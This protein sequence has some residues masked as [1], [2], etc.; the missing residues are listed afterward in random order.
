MTEEE[1]LDDN[2]QEEE[3]GTPQWFWLTVLAGIALG[4]LVG[5]SYQSKTPPRYSA[6]LNV[7]V[8]P[9]AAPLLSFTVQPDS[10]QFSVSSQSGSIRLSVLGITETEPTFDAMRSFIAEFEQDLERLAR[11]DYARVRAEL[12]EFA[13]NPG[14]YD[15]A[16]EYR[17]FF[18]ALD[19][20]RTELIT[21]SAEEVHPLHRSPLGSAIL[22]AMLGAPVGAAIAMGF[23]YL[24]R[25]DLFT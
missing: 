8:D 6:A 19:G 18:D 1:K 13:N 10:D 2:T 24:R 4:A 16:L 11:D 5:F 25:R 15:K 14:P 17:R 21:V 12:I 9:V 7:S 23:A 20:G 3:I 22:G